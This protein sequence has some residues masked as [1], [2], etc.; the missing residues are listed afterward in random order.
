MTAGRFR[1]P[2]SAAQP[3]R[4]ASQTRATVYTMQDTEMLHA[5]RAVE[6]RLTEEFEGRV[7]AEEIARRT[8]ESLHKFHTARIKTFVPV[9][10][11]REVRDEVRAALRRRQSAAPT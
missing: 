5:M 1:C 4:L 6:E 8:R 7:S 9:F 2:A 3:E 10:V 11:Q